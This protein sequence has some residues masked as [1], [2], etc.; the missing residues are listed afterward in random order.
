MHSDL[1]LGQVTAQSHDILLLSAQT[2]VC[3][4]ICFCLPPV[5]PCHWQAPDVHQQACFMNTVE[6][7]SDSWKS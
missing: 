3:N 6:I 1:F 2:V 5:F 4:S 7:F